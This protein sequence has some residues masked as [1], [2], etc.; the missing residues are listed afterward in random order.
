[1]FKFLHSLSYMLVSLV[2]F[3]T[4]SGLSGHVYAKDSSETIKVETESKEAGKPNKNIR[5]EVNNSGRAPVEIIVPVAFFMTFP[6]CMFLFFLFKYRSTREKQ[7]T[8]RA[9]VENGAQIPPEMFMDGKTPLKPIDRDRKNGIVFT[10]GSIGLILC[11]LLS[12]AEPSGI[13][14]IGLIPLLTGLG[15]LTNWKI[16]TNSQKAL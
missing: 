13:W 2:L 3:S 7:I 12:K 5:V 6:A 9:M 1:M 10:L 14:S 4:L 16:A 11:L 8:L 15:Y